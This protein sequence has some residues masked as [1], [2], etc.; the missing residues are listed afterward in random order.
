LATDAGQSVETIKVDQPAERPKTSQ[1]STTTPYI[2]ED[3]AYKPVSTFIEHP[4]EADDL[5]HRRTFSNRASLLEGI[6]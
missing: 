1:L 5:S 3:P 2:L 4:Q 6:I